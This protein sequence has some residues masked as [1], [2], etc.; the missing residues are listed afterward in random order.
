MD[1][2]TDLP[3]LRLGGCVYVKIKKY[4]LSLPAP[5]V[6]YG[7]VWECMAGL[8]SVPPLAPYQGVEDGRM[9]ERIDGWMSD[10]SPF[11]RILK[12]CQ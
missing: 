10:A 2:L 6:A 7:P 5:S 4:T 12:P 1:S 9:K 8:G 3:R 11:F